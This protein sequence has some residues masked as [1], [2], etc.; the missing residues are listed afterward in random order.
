M[1]YDPLEYALNRFEDAVLECPPRMKYAP[2]RKELID[3]ISAL[4][5]RVKELEE[6]VGLAEAELDATIVTG[7]KREVYL[8]LLEK[9][10][11]AAR[12][13]DK[14]CAVMGGEDC[15]PSIRDLRQ[16]LLAL[17]EGKG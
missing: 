10:A 9:V 14:S 3:G 6:R 1:P 13:H 16:A 12:R 4:R 11:S 8:A 7:R 5:E 2:A 17:E 15:F